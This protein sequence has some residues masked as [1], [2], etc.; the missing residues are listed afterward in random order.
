MGTTLRAPTYRL[1]FLQWLRVCG[2]A[3]VAICIWSVICLRPVAAQERF[4]WEEESLHPAYLVD[5]NRA[6][7]HAAISPSLFWISDDPAALMADPNG[8]SEEYEYYEEEAFETAPPGA[9]ALRGM[10][11]WFQH[12]PFFGHGIDDPRDPRRHF[13][14]GVPLEGTSWRNRPWHVGLLI[15]FL[16]GGEVANGTVL[17]DSGMMWGLRFGNDFDHYWGWELRVAT[18]QNDL[19]RIDTGVPLPQNGRNSY[20]DINI[21]YY[22]LGDT[23]WRPY[24]SVGVGA[25]THGFADLHGHSYDETTASL[26]VGLGVKYFV[27]PGWSIRADFTNNISFGTTNAPGTDNISL[28]VGLDLHF[29]GRRRVYFPW[30]SSFQVW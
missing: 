17:Q 7:E 10:R 12:T 27:R 18:S 2:A 23:R 15:G 1:R 29:G 30:D 19:N 8:A 4:W 16:D 26:P 11:R 24:I 28:T 5:L 3:A 6:H 21:L 22:P 14:V 25:A 13:G 9:F 20:Y